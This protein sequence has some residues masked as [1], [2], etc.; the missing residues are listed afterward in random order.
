MPQ[1]VSGH[2][3]EDLKSAMGPYLDST[4]FFPDC[5]IAPPRCVS[6]SPSTSWCCPDTKLLFYY[7]HF[8]CVIDTRI[9]NTCNM[10]P[11]VYYTPKLM[12][13]PKFVSGHHSSFSQKDG[14]GQGQTR[15]IRSRH[16][17]CTLCNKDP[18]LI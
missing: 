7:A 13:G 17:F 3:G 6:S 8:G 15:K 14:L 1:E 2:L 10:P 5:P 18:L 12:T 11:S 4:I 16:H 9:R